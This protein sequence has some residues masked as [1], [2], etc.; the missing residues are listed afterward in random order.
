MAKKKDYSAEAAIGAGGALALG[1]PAVSRVELKARELRSNQLGRKIEA[2]AANK[3]AKPERQYSAN[4]K[5]YLAEGPKK[6]YERQKATKEWQGKL[7]RLQNKANKA[8][9]PKVFPKQTKLWATGLA[10]GV[11]LAY[12]G[13]QKKVSKRSN[14]E[15]DVNAGF[16]G[17]LAGFGAYQGGSLALKPIEKPLERK[18]KSDSKLKA[19]QQAHKEKHLPKKATAGHPGWIKYSRE[20][21]KELPGAKLRR[22]Q[23][24][25]HSGKSGGLLTL[26]A[27]AAGAAAGVKYDRKQRVKKMSTVSAFGVDHGDEFSKKKKGGRDHLRGAATGALAGGAAGG[28]AGAGLAGAYGNSIGNSMSQTYR[29]ASKAQKLKR[30]GPGMAA[31]GAVGAIPVGAGGAVAGGV[32]GRKS[33]KY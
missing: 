10:T 17:G 3:P 14:K 24:Y 26:G 33:K 4:T 25:T 29:T 15:R 21:P 11:P 7:N 13:A 18:I 8:A 23:A 9:K 6:K 2:H 28:A 19:I 16:A 22:V 31:F 20:Y 27:T 32:I 12:Y 1:T 30:L 5:R